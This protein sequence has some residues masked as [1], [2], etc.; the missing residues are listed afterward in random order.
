MHPGAVIRSFED[1]SLWM[2]SESCVICGDALQGRQRRF[3]SR[4][5]KNRD[6]NNRHQTYSSQQARGLARKLELILACG[7][8]CSRCGY[9]RNVAALSWHHLDPELKAFNLDVRSL[10]N[11]NREAIDAEL[12]KCIL[13]CANC[14]AETHFPELGMDSVQ[15]LKKK[16]DHSPVLDIE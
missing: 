4:H 3:C 10:S 2:K 7:G 11:R 9:A 6:T 15:R 1:Y 14:H 5:C 12:R 16:L 13:L 8:K